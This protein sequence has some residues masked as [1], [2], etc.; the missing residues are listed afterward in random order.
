MVDLFSREARRQILRLFFLVGINL[1]RSD[2]VSDRAN[3]GLLS[4]HHRPAGSS[5]FLPDYTV[6]HPQSRVR[7][8]AAPRR[9]FQRHFLD[10][11]EISK[12][13]ERVLK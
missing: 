8:N 1:R 9:I 10:F 3:C 11:S 12:G 6:K 13:I 4:F 5:C 2:N 7:Y